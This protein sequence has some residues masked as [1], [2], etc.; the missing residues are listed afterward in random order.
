[1]IY[2]WA[3]FVVYYSPCPTPIEVICEPHDHTF[4]AIAV[5]DLNS[6]AR[7]LQDNGVN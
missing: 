4:M 2:C 1:M 5:S 7:L 3:A 6:W